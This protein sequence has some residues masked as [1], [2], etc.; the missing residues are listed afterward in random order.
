MCRA[1]RGEDRDP[2][3]G[4]R[5]RRGEVPQCLF[6]GAGGVSLDL[7]LEEAQQLVDVLQDRSYPEIPLLWK[8]RGWCAESN[9]PAHRQWLLHVIRAQVS[10]N[11]IFPAFPW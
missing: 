4:V 10:Q 6:I 5:V 11:E 3:A 8:P 7:T 2:L 1:V 9:D